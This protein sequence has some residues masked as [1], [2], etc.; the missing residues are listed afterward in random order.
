M[1][2][3]TTRRAHNRDMTNELHLIGS[4]VLTRTGQFEHMYAGEAKTLCGQDVVERTTEGALYPCLSCKRS[5][6]GG[7]LYRA[8]RAAKVKA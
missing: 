6:K 5:E 7:G 3:A 8:R 4:L 1:H 2:A